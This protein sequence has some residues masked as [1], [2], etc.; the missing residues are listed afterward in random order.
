MKSTEYQ[1]TIDLHENKLDATYSIV[2]LEHIQHVVYNEKRAVFELATTSSL[3][4]SVRQA[5]KTQ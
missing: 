5:Q 2:N 3:R 4:I 1:A